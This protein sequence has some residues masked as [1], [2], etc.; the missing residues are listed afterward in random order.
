[1]SWLCDYKTNWTNYKEYDCHP[2][3]FDDFIESEKRDSWKERILA[4]LMIVLLQ[5]I[6]GQ[7]VK[8][9]D[10]RMEVVA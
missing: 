5:D 8:Y 9:T 10:K 3:T 4:F 2:Q 1:L 7:N 6:N